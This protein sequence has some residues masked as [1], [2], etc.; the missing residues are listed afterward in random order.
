M[1]GELRQRILE[2]AVATVVTLTL[3]TVERTIQPNWLDRLQEVVD[4]VHLERLHG[5][6]VVRSREDDAWTGGQ[7]FHDLKAAQPGH[8]DIEE[9]HVGAGQCHLLEPALGIGL[10]A[11]DLDTARR[12]QHPRETLERQRLVVDE[13]RANRAPD[14][15]ASSRPARGIA[16]VIS[17]PPSRGTI[18]SVAAPP[19]RAARRPFRLSSPWP[20]TIASA[21]KPGPSSQTPIMSRPSCADA[22]TRM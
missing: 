10:P 13:I 14:C 2:P 12:L 16:T 18:V 3:D 6:L 11:H 22:S 8:V 5:V 21:E 19:K 20:G 1:L 7:P 15:H 17:V 9:Q 4:R